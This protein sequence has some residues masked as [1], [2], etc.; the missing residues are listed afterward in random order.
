MPE[1]I[2]F[3]GIP[4]PWGPILVYSLVTLGFVVMLVR[5]YRYAS[6]WH[7]VGQPESHWDRPLQRLSRLAT[8]AVVQLRLLSQAYPGIMHAALAWG[9]FVFFLG[10]ALATINGHLVKFLQGN[11]YLAYKF[12][13][14]LFSLI[15]LAGAGMAGYR[16]F[17]RRPR[18]LTLAPR[19]TW[20]LVSI[21]F[22]VLNGLIV[23]SLRLAVQ[24]PAWALWSPAGWALAEIWIALRI[25]TAALQTL[26]LAFY[27][28]HFLTVALF[29]ITFPVGTLVHIF[30]GTLNTFFSEIN[31]PTG[32]L[33]PIPLDTAGQPIFA[34]RMG[35]LTWKQLLDGDACTE[36]GRCQD[37]CPATASGLALN[38]KTIITLIS[39]GLHSPV[40]NPAAL[41]G[42]P[43][44]GSLVSEEE[45]WACTTCGACRQECPVLVEHVD[46]IV[47]MRRS[48]V[49]DARVGEKL[50]TAL[51]NLRSC[52]NSF[53]EPASAR[54]TWTQGLSFQ[55]KDAR[56][57]P[58]KYLW[59]TGDYAAYSPD[60]IGLTR[61]T[62]SVFKQAGLDFG[63]LYDGEINSGNDTRRA[64]EEG[65]FEMLMEKNCLTLSACEFEA[66]VTTDPHTYNT[67][68]NEYPQD[69]LVGR[70]VLHTSELLD[71]MISRGDLLLAPQ[72][73]QTVTYHDPCYLGRY[74]RV[75]EAPRRV[76]RAA[77]CTLVE[78]PRSR[79]KAYCCGAGGGRIWMEEGEMTERPAESRIRE[80]AA[81]PGVTAFVTAC[82]KDIVMYHDA[83][84][85]TG[86]QN[87]LVV[88]DLIE[89]VAEGLTPAGK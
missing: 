1:R 15:F 80:A 14:D 39:G 29:F 20:S 75:Y 32:R 22:I 44:A 47:D 40:A 74:N 83:L 36:C 8:Y 59:I 61:L 21:T 88:K 26:H 81:L 68:K 76:L 84:T 56:Q 70:P 57:Q 60:L 30:T 42:R 73:N 45:L 53:G 12:I 24:Q 9:F 50:Q 46:T 79:S 10:T 19:F 87:R 49:N 82:P 7:Q 6:L 17:I 34:A 37:A 28:I 25:P 51:L 54:G 69:V 85:T 65:L 33:A 3:W 72:G 78:M 43:L 41:A 23:E 38:P 58:V 5:L 48:L 2:D 18:R 16:R 55:V 62:A 31:R 52:G 89:F 4:Q 11:P 13:L 77:G 27:T 71:Q 66:I 64:G 63:I 35:G 86:V 67:L